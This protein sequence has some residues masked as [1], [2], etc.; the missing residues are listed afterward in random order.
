MSALLLFA[1]GLIVGIIATLAAGIAV[2]RM[3]PPKR[4]EPPKYFACVGDG[5]VLHPDSSAHG[6]APHDWSGPI[7][8][9]PRRAEAPYRIAKT[10]L[11]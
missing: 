9:P 2:M 5:P 7:W 3:P 6:A 4:S 8:N 11:Y 10:E 1:A